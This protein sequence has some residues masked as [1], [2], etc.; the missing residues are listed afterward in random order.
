MDNNKTFFRTRTCGELRM[1]HVG[2]AVTLAGFLENFREV[3]ATL[4]FAVLRD[5][6]GTTQ[7][8]CESEELVKT[9]KTLNKESTVQVSGTVRERDSKN[10]KLPTGDIE[11]V[12]AK[13][14]V[15]GRC[16][17]NE[18]PFPVN[19]SREA[20]ESQRLKFRYLDLRNPEVK[21]NIVLRCQVVSALR[22]AMT[23]HGF[24]EITTP[25]LTA[26]S[27]EGARDYLVPSRKHPGKFYALPQ[28]PQ[29]FKQLLMA[30]G[31][32][33]Y[34]QIAPCF[35]D[36]DARGDRSPGEFYQLDMEM[37]FAG[38]EDVFAVLE[39]VLPPIFAKYGKYGAA[40]SAP[41]QRISF[42]DAM[43][44]YGSDKPD[45]R[46]RLKLQDATAVLAGC[47][48]GPFEGQTVKA[49]C[50]PGFA[51][52][53]KQIDKL[54]ADVEVQ[55]GQKVYW[56]RLDENG[57]IVGGIA[58]FLQECKGQVVEALGLQP[59]TFVGLT[60]GKKLTAQ[61]TGG[62]LIKQL[63]PLCPGHFDKERYEFCW[64]VDFPMY[65]IGE[66][67]GELEFCHNP[68]SMPN[69]GAEI[70]KKAAAGEVDPLS[71]TA[72][73]Y[74]LVCNGVELS[75]GAVRNH[76]PEIMI[77]AFQ[78]VRLGEEDVKAKFPAMYN[79]FTYGAPP[80]A[81]IA[82]GVDR[83]VMLLAGED[84][85]REI[86][87]FPMNKNAQDLMMGAP[88]IVEQKQLDELNI[89]CTKTGDEV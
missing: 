48:F 49:V 70:L 13:I 52:T 60:A 31:F 68:F 54:C 5:F 65:E 39:D 34:F 9:F 63:A 45:L 30:S 26:S 67:S 79:A 10:P 78:L 40:S 12:P 73:Q 36:E 66:E 28:A 11:V 6:Y 29:Q 37:A 69:G 43:E 55:A 64:I 32:D 8:V 42:L 88:G 35:R 85:I 1:E 4:G 84:S 53:R 20:D 24:M 44:T 89:M 38:Q 41:F 56:F 19:R 61:K 14:E 87:P 22:Q 46:I 72:F 57:E 2:E 23:G 21:D 71:I 17:H 75:S 50:V 59:N 47:G 83:M 33:K 86:I 62:V 80:H 15:L 3:G 25:I 77:E 16:R 82:P 74:D 27:P 7:V 81:G 76:D 58:K 18:L 51:A